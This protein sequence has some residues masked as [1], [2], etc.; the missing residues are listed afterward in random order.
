VA[1]SPSKLKRL[2][3]D[4]SEDEQRIR[5]LRAAGKSLK[6][7][8]VTS[9]EVGEPTATNQVKKLFQSYKGLSYGLPWETL[10]YVELL[11]TYNPDYSQAVENIKM[12]ANSGHE[13][14]IVANSELRQRRV[15]E[16][17]E[18]KARTIQEAHGGIDGVID[19]LLDQA[20]TYGAMCGEW[21]LNDELTDVIDFIDINP[22]VIRFFWD[23]DEGRYLPYQMLFGTQLQKARDEGKTLINNCVKLNE[24]TF[25]YFAFDAAPGSPYGTPPFLAALSNIAIQRDMVHNMAQIVKK[26][27]LLAV[28]DLTIERLSP[29]PGESDDDFAIRAGEY[30]D[31]YVTVAEEMVRD[32]G[33]VHFDDVTTT[34]WNIGGNAAGATNIH[35]ANEEMVF[36]GLKSMPSVQGRSYST[37]ETYAGVAYEIILRNTRKY[38]RAAK[39]MIESGYWLMVTMA[40]GIEQP[41]SISLNFQENRTLNRLG[42]AQAE[43]AEI[44]NSHMLWY[45][46]II[47]QI[48]VANRHG[49]NEPKEAF[50]RP[51]SPPKGASGKQ[52]DT[53]SNSDSGTAPVSEGK[54]HTRLLSSEDEDEQDFAEV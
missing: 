12:L 40:P 42:E 37:T 17:L 43:A 20:A 45:L 47:D 2:A 8:R 41:N 16:L 31:Q 22:K 6:T 32:G 34:T 1:A 36:S 21:V 50:D 15:K 48:Q 52:D 9:A 24:L 44:A 7:S 29:Q 14:F 51:P 53:Q 3:S 35:K 26:I 38:Q 11:A 33:M 49:E 13:L 10:D 39:R 30:L 46:G 5:A 25:R 27:G 28:I 54:A 19:K 4:L 23:D 18:N